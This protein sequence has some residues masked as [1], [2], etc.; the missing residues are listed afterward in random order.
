[1]AVRQDEARRGEIE[2]E[3]QHGGDEQHSREGGE[4]KRRLDEQSRHQ[5]QH[6]EDDRDRERHVE[7]RRRQRQ[8]EHD[9]NRHHADRERDVAA[10]EYGADIGEVRQAKPWS[11]AA[12]RYVTHL[13]RR[14]PPRPILGMKRACRGRKAA[15]SRQRNRARVQAPSPVRR[16]NDSGAH[17]GKICLP[18]G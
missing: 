4:L 5:D 18:Y 3:P 11:A 6:R 16:V 7:Q 17:P 12:C 13:F 15:G 1:V 2:R 8:N 9:Q 10:P 14:C